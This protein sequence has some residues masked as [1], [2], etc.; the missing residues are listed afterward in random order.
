MSKKKE[1]LK[2]KERKKWKAKLKKAEKKL[3]QAE[4]AQQKA[5]KK[6]LDKWKKLKATI[7]P[8]KKAYLETKQDRKK[9]QKEY[10]TLV[11]AWDTL[12]QHKTELQQALGAILPTKEEHANT[13]GDTETLEAVVPKSTPDNLQR[14]EGIGP[15]IASILKGAG[16]NSYA[17]LSESRQDFLEE[18]LAN[19]GPHFRM[20]DTSTWAVQAVYA[21]KGQWEAL[22]TFQEDLKT[23]KKE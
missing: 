22:A 7:K 23:D 9:K 8:F 16:I 2:K 5:K 4:K 12:K 19:A 11:E 13:V 6:Y 15:K 1:G 17:K 3:A 10:E 20:H 14:I 18:L 21:S